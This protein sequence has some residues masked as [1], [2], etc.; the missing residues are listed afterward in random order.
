MSAADLLL[1]AAGLAARGVI[2]A[3][4]LAL[5]RALGRHGDGGEAGDDQAGP[6]AAGAG[7]AGPDD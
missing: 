6:G 3:V 1:E 2:G 7:E 5:D 4:E